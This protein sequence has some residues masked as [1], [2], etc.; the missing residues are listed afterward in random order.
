M[1]GDYPDNDVIRVGDDYY[2]ISTSMNMMPG[3]PI[4]KSKDLVNWEYC[5]YCVESMSDPTY[6]F[7]GGDE[8]NEG[9][10]ATSL[11]YNNGVFYVLFNSNRT[12]AYICTATD[13]AGPWAMTALGVQLYDP[14]M[15]FDDDGRV[16]VVHGQSTL[17]LTELNADCKSVKTYNQE[18]HVCT[19]GYYCEGS[20][21]Y[22]RNGYY[23]ILN[24]PTWS[25][26]SKKEVA[27]RAKSLTGP[28]EEVDIMASFMNW[29]G[30]GVHQGAIVDTPSGEWWAI[31]FQ[32][33][34]PFGRVPTLQPVTWINDWP[35]M[36][37]N[38]SGEAVVTYKKP[39]VGGTY[40]IKVPAT[41]DEF[42]STTLGL[43][44]QWN[45]NP[46]NSKWSLSERPGYM[47]LKTATV[48]SDL[49][50]ARNTLTQRVQ[51]PE[52]TAVIKMDITNMEN[53][54]VAGLTLIET[55]NNFIGVKKVNGV[56]SIILSDMGNEIASAAF[57]G[58]EIWFKAEI[59]KLSV[60]TNYY[61]ST[62]G[63]NFT[64][65]GDPLEM[66]HSGYVGVRFGIFNYATSALGG[67]V[68]IDWY[69]FNSEDHYGNLF[70]VGQTI[71]AERYDD[72]SGC[73]FEWATDQIIGGKD[74]DICSITNNAWLQFD[75][76]NF[77]SGATSFDARV[78][79]GASGGSIEIRLDSPTG[80]LLGTCAVNSTDGWQNW[81]TKSCSLSGA[82]GKQKVYLV[83]KGGSGNL[84]NLNW[85]RFN[86]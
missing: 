69:H 52:C 76:I 49:Q 23:Y 13:P 6:N 30:G 65:L 60:K 7:E 47:R 64:Q 83:F 40:P 25:K 43:Q 3:C 66:H 44:W 26:G 42:N 12:G 63:V 27:H 34:Y 78:A 39:D 74:Q 55:A 59:P 86:N 84:F 9:P 5:G 8:Y 73:S 14:G 57:T 17:Y 48:T 41:S 10:W 46:D 20:R 70:T 11:R 1:W 79:S 51:G 71:E 77:G 4:M 80:T 19:S 16:Y 15:F 50:Y 35:Y 37:L 56:K 33:R 82:T 28:F 81:T 53:G 38:D 22:K 21:V 67:Y 2:M 72:K 31:I 85:F 29:T 32:D 75:Q 62:D 54:D 18:I 61:Y 68:D 45:H 36:G 24:T 58:N